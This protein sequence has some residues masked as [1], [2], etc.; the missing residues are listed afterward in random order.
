M[1]VTLSI[2]L[3]TTFKPAKRVILTAIVIKSYKLSL[4]PKE[5][6]VKHSTKSLK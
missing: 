2:L 1:L 6:P 4:K 3:S 5:L